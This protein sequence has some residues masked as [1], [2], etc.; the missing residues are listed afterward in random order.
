ML[1]ALSITNSRAS[2]HWVVERTFSWFGQNRR[3]AKGCENL[4][5]LWPPSRPSHPP[6]LPSGGLP[7]RSS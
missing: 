2:R 6:S 7:G 1:S 3:R 5:E 4:A